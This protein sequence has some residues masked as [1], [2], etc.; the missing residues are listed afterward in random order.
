MNDK[1][2][3]YLWAGYGLVTAF[4][5]G[6]IT[7]MLYPRE[8][9]T[10]PKAAPNK[11]VN[12]TSVSKPKPKTTKTKP[13]PNASRKGALNFKW[14]ARQLMSVSNVDR[15]KAVADLQT[16]EPADMQVISR[17][18]IDDSTR[19]DGVFILAELGKRAGEKVMELESYLET[20][21]KE[22]DGHMATWLNYALARVTGNDK[23]VKAIVAY[24]DD[25][26]VVPRYQALLALARLGEDAKPYMGKIES[27]TADEAEEVRR[28]S[29]WASTYLQSG[30][31]K[32]TGGKTIAGGSALDWIKKL[33]SPK[34][35][36]RKMAE[37]ALLDAGDEIIGD[38]AAGLEDVS[39]FR[40]I[41]QL[42]TSSPKVYASLAPALKNVQVGTETRPNFSAA[43]WCAYSLAA[44]G[45]DVDRNIDRMTN[46]MNQEK[47]GEFDRA[48]TMRLL[49]K[50]GSKAIKAEP[51]LL[52]MEASD[53]DQ[54]KLAAKEALLNIRGKSTPGVQVVDI[55][56]G[57]KRLSEWLATLSRLEPEAIAQTAAVANA[58]DT[59]G[60]HMVIDGIKDASRMRGACLLIGSKSEPCSEA[61]EFLELEHVRNRLIKNSMAL[62]YLDYALL[63]V[64]GEG[65]YFSDLVEKLTGKEYALEFEV[66]Q[67]L[68]L[69]GPKAKEALPAIK[70]VRE[71]SKDSRII[72]KADKVIKILS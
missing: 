2:K 28:A 43:L 31:L 48:E 57:G 45:V 56:V 15:E 19:L 42:V 1:Y 62:V 26:D 67:L 9:S 10:V 51:S 34:L 25:K 44:M 47:T 8:D 63:R 41:C 35:R 32:N 12:K 40:P 58:I 60:L 59:K 38:L 5:I 6:Y 20:S 70:Q 37:R 69:M 11:V 30:F 16:F 71:R 17:M 24:L 18:L 65:K 66:L 14:I 4:V 21:L 61:K 55:E 33:S 50:L 49:G 39:L 7:Y 36:V 23:Y 64:T 46:L 22:H 53:S 3:V 68:E 29:K 72:E 52:K 54:L 13:T 27:L